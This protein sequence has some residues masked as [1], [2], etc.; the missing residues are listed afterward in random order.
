MKLRIVDRITLLNILPDK[1]N[2]VTMGLL[3]ELK[4]ALAF[5]QKEIED[6][7]IEAHPSPDGQ[8]TGYSWNESK[9]P[10]KDVKIG[11]TLTAL[12]VGILKEADKKEELDDQ[13]DDL[14]DLF[15]D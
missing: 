1:G 8:P 5:S 6:V 2:H 11:S 9:D 13:M 14:Y 15:V 4:K 7:K 3:R 10:K 12:I